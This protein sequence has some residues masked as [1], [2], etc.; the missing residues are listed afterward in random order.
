MSNKFI[1][2]ITIQ[3][4]KSIRE[5][6]S[7][8]L[9]NIN[10]LIGANGSGKSNFLGFFN[11]VRNIIEQNLGGYSAKKG[12]ADGILTF[13]RK[14]SPYLES[15]IELEDDKYGFRL[16]AADDNS[17]YFKYERTKYIRD[18][19][20]HVESNLDN[21]NFLGAKGFVQ[22]FKKIL[23]YHFH[24]VGDTSPIKSD[25]YVYEK[26][27]LKFDGKNI[28]AF[29]YRLYT[30]EMDSYKLIVRTVRMVVPDFYDFY[31]PDN[32]KDDDKIAL[33]WINKNDRDSIQHPSFLSDGSLRFICLATILLQPINLIPDIVIIDEPELGLHP[34]ALVILANLIERI[35]LQKQFI[36]AT[37]SSQIVDLFNANDIIVVNKNSDGTSS[38]ER[39]DNSKL[40]SWLEEY[41]VSD[42]WEMNLIGGLP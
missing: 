40:N 7:F 12:K 14:S 6:N 1:R 27:K 35:S 19:S 8:Q 41:N 20:T 26:E 31:F 28:A 21:P 15:V 16:L 32:V 17:F 24:D 29:L 11:F 42:L 36:I 30:E 25:D 23:Q 4:F 22:Q 3:N 18:S 38:F 5:L 13:G 39:L 9:N 2:K 37:Q 34:Q 10:I 33:R